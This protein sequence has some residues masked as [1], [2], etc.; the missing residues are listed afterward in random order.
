MS[1]TEGETPRDEHVVG[2]G[3]FILVSEHDA[4]LDPHRSLDAIRDTFGAYRDTLNSSVAYRSWNPTTIRLRN[5]IRRDD[6]RRLDMRSHWWRLA[7]VDG[8]GSG[9]SKVEKSGS[10]TLC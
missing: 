3:C 6:G 5:S 10:R 9:S 7:E 2:Y 4:I 8:N 1:L